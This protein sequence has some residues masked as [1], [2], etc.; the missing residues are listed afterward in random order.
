MVTAYEL[1]TFRA[2]RLCNWLLG[3]LSALPYNAAQIRFGYRGGRCSYMFSHRLLKKP[4][5]YSSG[6]VTAIQY[7]DSRASS[8]SVVSLS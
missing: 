5:V 1:Y 2:Q 7:K 6:E 3:A 8:V 4:P